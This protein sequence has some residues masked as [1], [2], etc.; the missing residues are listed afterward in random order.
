MTA[1]SALI[2]GALQ[3]VHTAHTLT[4]DAQGEGGRDSNQFSAADRADAYGCRNPS[5]A[6]SEPALSV[7]VGSHHPG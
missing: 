6:S 2:R 5:Q 4:R 7:E 3:K 1:T